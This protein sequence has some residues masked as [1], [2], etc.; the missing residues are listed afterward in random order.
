MGLRRA[1]LAG[2]LLVGALVAGCTAPEPKNAPAGFDVVILTEAIGTP[3]QS[4]VPVGAPARSAYV[5]MIPSSTSIESSAAEIARRN[6][7]DPPCIG[8]SNHDSHPDCSLWV[9]RDFYV[10][11]L[12]NQQPPLLEDNNDGTKTLHMAY[13][14]LDEGR[15]HFRLTER[16]AFLVELSGNALADYPNLAK[17]DCRSMVYE[18]SGTNALAA[19]VVSGAAHVDDDI[20]LVIE[21]DATIAI[22]WTARCGS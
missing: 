2:V 8:H 15:I 5:M 6:T 4:G 9:R 22:H 19:T 21:G 7:F 20:K 14:P 18:Q 12:S 1:A 10:L 16:T 13:Y 3:G 11:P 17:T